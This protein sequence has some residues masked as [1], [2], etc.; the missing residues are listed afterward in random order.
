MAV[1]RRGRGFEPAGACSPNQLGLPARRS[2]ELRLAV[3]WREVAGEALA[4]RAEA[5][6]VTRGTLEVQVDERRWEVTVLA[7]LP[8]LA[9]R[10]A[11]SYPALGVK[12]CRLLV[13]GGEGVSRGE[14]LALE[15]EEHREDRDSPAPRTAEVEQV[16]EEGP[17]PEGD[18]GERLTRVGEKYLARSE[19]R[20]VR[21]RS[22]R[23]PAEPSDPR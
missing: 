14:A 22:G 23:G 18:L 3:A 20:A 1:R 7:L 13:S 9:A 15:V 11:R 5:V 10:L 19:G 4:R 6:R 12:R 17:S 2:R 8:R 21:K 16:E